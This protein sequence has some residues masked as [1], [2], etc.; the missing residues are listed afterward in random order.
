MGVVLPRSVFAA[1]GSAG[2]RQWLVDHAPPRRI[3]FLLNKGSWAFDMEPR[4]SVALLI[5]ERGGD[6]SA[7]QVAGVAASAAAFAAQ[8]R[9]PGLTLR[10]GA[11]G[12][13]LEVPLLPT[14]EDADL[15]ATLRATGPFPFGGG[16]WRCF[17]VGEF[18]ETN[19]RGLW[20]NAAEGRPL[21]KGA[22]F[23]QFLP[24][25]AHERP[26]PATPQALAKARKPRPGSGS[27]HAAS[28][29]L[30]QRVAAVERTV[31]RAR[32]AFRDVTR[33]TDSRTVRA[34][35]IPPKHF[36]TNKAPYLAFID[37]DLRAEAACLA[38]LNSLPFDW[39]AR[40]FVEINLNFFVLEGLRV[41]DLDEE[42]FNALAD[43][44][45]RLS[46]PDG[47]FLDFAVA[48]GVSVDL[49][50]DEQRLGLRAEID[51]RVAHAW[52]L[53]AQELEVVFRDFTLDAV[54]AA[55]RDRVRARFAELG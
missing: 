25:G 42:T 43:A 15:L 48:T 12:G 47:R 20:E 31:D 46:C 55:Y 16:R 18:H 22:S 35:L 29:S 8:V 50:D 45:A 26:C 3:D 13:A 41:P 53:S 11:L 19:D 2:F 34:C 54:S 4:Y 23:D 36:L 52:G 44:S 17:P 32:V 6:D 40:R 33:A 27:L 37:D 30:Q 1:K 10:R 24:L 14:Q 7:M 28:S 49:L 51:A 39:Q 9:T 38:V 5:A 21:W